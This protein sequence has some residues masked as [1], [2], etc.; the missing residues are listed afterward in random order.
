VRVAKVPDP[1]AAV[2]LAALTVLLMGTDSGFSCKRPHVRYLS[3]NL[4]Q[5]LSLPGIVTICCASALRRV[6][7][8]NTTGHEPD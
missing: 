1:R 4:K 3:S 6:P 7:G 5:E 2:G 8:I